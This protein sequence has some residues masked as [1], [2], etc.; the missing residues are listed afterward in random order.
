MAEEVNEFLIF[1]FSDL[2]ILPRL[3]I[4]YRKCH[5]VVRLFDLTPCGFLLHL[6]ITYPAPLLS[7]Q[8][9]YQIII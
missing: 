2:F 8:I 9:S 7:D 6:V 4:S 3:A 5:A 1:T